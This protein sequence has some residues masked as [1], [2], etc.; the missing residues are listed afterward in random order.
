MVVRQ[1]IYS[2]AARAPLCRRTLSA[3][4]GC[5]AAALP[6][7]ASAQQASDDP[8]PQRASAAYF[9]ERV[10][11]PGGRVG[12]EVAALFRRP[13]ELLMGG[14]FGGFALPGGYALMVLFEGGYRLTL[15]FGGFLDLR[16]GLGYTAGWVNGSTGLQVGNYF[17]LSALGGIGY[18]FFRLLRVPLSIMGRSGVMWRAGSGPDAGVTYVLDVGLAYQFGTGK[19]KPVT[20][21]VAMPPPAE[22]PNLDDPSAPSQ[23]LAPNPPETNAP[24]APPP[25]AAATMPPA[26]PLPPPPLVPAT[27]PPG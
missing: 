4:V 23:P 19:A 7:A 11:Q 17:T 15:P 24:N 13:H 3:L 26:P 6:V 9:G 20:L 14:S 10:V 18:D 5:A 21:P 1:T 8:R 2:T 22:A 12:Y 25:P 27:Q 16:P